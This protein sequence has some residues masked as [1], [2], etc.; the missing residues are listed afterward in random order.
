MLKPTISS[1]T[2]FCPRPPSFPP[3]IFRCPNFDNSPVKLKNISTKPTYF[4]EESK[5]GAGFIYLLI[6]QEKNYPA[7]SMYNIILLKVLTRSQEWQF[8]SPCLPSIRSQHSQTWGVD[9]CKTVYR[10]QA[11]HSCRL[12]M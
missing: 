11:P 8:C 6:A 2:V 3:T 4:R 12:R 9:P 1:A 7:A 10:R 5:N